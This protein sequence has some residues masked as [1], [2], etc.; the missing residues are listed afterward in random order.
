MTDQSQNAND[1]EEH[2]EEEFELE[3]LMTR[4]QGENVLRRLATGVA[5]G[6]VELG[7]DE[8]PVTVPEQFE[9]EVEY[10]EEED[11]AELE[12]ELEWSMADGE[13]VSPEEDE[14]DGTEEPETSEQ[15][16]DDQE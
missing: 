10:E 13:A 5:S 11:E 9:V 12:V 14:S 16:A 1:A 4:E 2:E 6:S 3:G 8:G 7:R 15:G